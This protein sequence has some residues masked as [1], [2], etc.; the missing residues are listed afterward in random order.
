MQSRSRIDPKIEKA[1]IETAISG[2]AMIPPVCIRQALRGEA[3]KLT[4]IAIQSKAYWGYSD[5]FM[6]ACVDELTVSSELIDDSE[7]HYVVAERETQIIGFYALEGFVDDEIEL[8]A[9]FVDP[10]HIGKGVGKSL[11][12]EAK[13]HAKKLGAKRLIFRATRMPNSFIAPLVGF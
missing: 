3:E 1:R 11:I 4:D 13:H 2:D 8:G 6:R 12:E 5:D 10:A 9:L 7:Y